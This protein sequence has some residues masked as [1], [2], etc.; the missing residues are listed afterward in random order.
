MN[1]LCADGIKDKFRHMFDGMYDSMLF[2]YFDGIFGTA[3][4]DN[5]DNPR[6]VMIISGDFYFVAGSTD[7]ARQLAE[8][9]GQNRWAV[10]I[11]DSG[12]WLHALNRFGKKMIAVERFH[13]NP[14]QNG[15]DEN[16]LRERADKIKDFSQ[17]RLLK[18]DREYYQK[19]LCS[20]WSAS[21]VSNFKDYEDYSEHGFGYIITCNDEIIS[22]TS[23][24]SYYG[25]GVEIEVSTC[26]NFRLK[27][28]AQ[29][30]A[31]QFLLECMK[32][33][34][35]PHWDARNRTSLAIAEKMGFVFRDKY[36]AYEFDRSVF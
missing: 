4:C 1:M 22:G 8:I 10:V 7:C 16:L 15:F 6:C 35:T 32:R 34:L 14:P 18:I 21:F 33:N 26:E 24:Y 5:T 31:S 36:T 13:T 3:V 29:I 20:D 12:E 27:G 17:F 9:I 23:T 19:A 28:L 30:T 2:S 25:G 11:A